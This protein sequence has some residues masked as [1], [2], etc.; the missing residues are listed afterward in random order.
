MTKQSHENHQKLLQLLKEAIEDERMAAQDY[1]NMSLGV[2]N[3]GHP[4]MVHAMERIA[5]DEDR[6]RSD[7]AKLYNNL[8]KEIE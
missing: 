4:E 8:L 7:L 2:R 6:H 3:L 5:L 1:R